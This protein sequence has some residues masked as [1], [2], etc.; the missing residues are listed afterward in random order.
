MAEHQWTTEKPTTCGERWPGIYCVLGHEKSSTY[1]I[2]YASGFSG[3]AAAHL[4]APPS[5]RDEW[6][7]RT[8]SLRTMQT[9]FL[10]K[11]TRSASF[12]G[13]TEGFRK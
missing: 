12:N 2:E 9:P 8:G 5:P 10:Y 3:P 11:W 7:C 13:R 4:P 1:S 6:Q